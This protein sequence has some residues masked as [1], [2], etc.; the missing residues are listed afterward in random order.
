M[1]KWIIPTLTR[2]YTGSTEFESGEMTLAT[3]VSISGA[4]CILMQLSLD[5]ELNATI[6]P[7]ALGKIKAVFNENA[8]AQNASRAIPIPA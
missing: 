8:Y 7:L 4:E 5:R 1:C 3:E 2:N 6:S